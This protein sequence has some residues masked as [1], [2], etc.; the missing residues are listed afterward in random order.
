MIDIFLLLEVNCLETN[1]ISLLANQNS[2]HSGSNISV[3]L[4]LSD[5]EVSGE[6]LLHGDRL[7]PHF[8]ADEHGVACLGGYALSREVFRA[9][10]SVVSKQEWYYC[11]LVS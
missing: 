1:I 10:F 9:G 3:N 11:H 4:G 8:H 2:D 5:N 6:L 7:A